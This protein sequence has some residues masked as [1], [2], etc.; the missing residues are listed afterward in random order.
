MWRFEW[1]KGSQPWCRSREM[2]NMLTWLIGILWFVTI[3]IGKKLNNLFNYSTVGGILLVVLFFLCCWCVKVRRRQ[4]QEKTV[5]PSFR[6]FP[7]V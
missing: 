3:K 6:Q 5:P 4:D 2:D 1:N 7:R